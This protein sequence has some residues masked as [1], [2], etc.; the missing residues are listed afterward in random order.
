MASRGR[1]WARDKLLIDVG[2]RRVLVD[3]V[4]EPRLQRAGVQGPEGAHE[5]SRTDELPEVLGEEVGQSAG[6]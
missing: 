5:G 6:R 4:D 1:C 3:R 2:A